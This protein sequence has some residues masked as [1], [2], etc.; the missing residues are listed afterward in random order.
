MS[1]KIEVLINMIKTFI[2][3]TKHDYFWRLSLNDP[4][5]GL[6]PD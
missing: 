2:L 6:D 1:R 3:D 4:C 5:K